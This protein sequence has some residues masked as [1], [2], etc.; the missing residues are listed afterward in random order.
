MNDASEVFKRLN[1]MLDEETLKQIDSFAKGLGL[2]RSSAIRF[3]CRQYMQSQKTIQS[4][5]DMI[6]AYK[7]E[8]MRNVIEGEPVFRNPKK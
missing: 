3:M 4:F 7:A 5:T 6:D 2:N 8:Q 1:I